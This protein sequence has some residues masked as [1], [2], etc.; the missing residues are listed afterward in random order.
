M[1][2]RAVE[3]RAGLSP[4]MQ[5]QPMPQIGKKNGDGGSHLPST[6]QTVKDCRKAQSCIG[7]SARHGW[8][9]LAR[10]EAASCLS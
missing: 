4:G 6:Y 1:L 7:A 10:C 2:R 9:A 8:P 5:G 3:M